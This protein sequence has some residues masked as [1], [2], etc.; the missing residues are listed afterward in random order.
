MQKSLT[1]FLD[2][3]FAKY[4]Y[5]VLVLIFV[6]VAI[7]MWVVF[8]ILGWALVLGEVLFV[9]SL[10]CLLAGLNRPS[11]FDKL[12]KGN[13]NKK[14]IGIVFGIA[15]LI[16]FIFIS[17][18]SFKSG[19]QEYSPQNVLQEVMI[20]V[21]LLAICFYFLPTFIAYKRNK[22]NKIAIFALDLCLGWT[23]VGWVIA[24]V[25]SLTFEGK[26]K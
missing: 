24:L 1:E 7:M 18:V 10:F 6:L 3:A 11:W 21:I 4:F 12:F 19:K 25:W 23:L 13:A 26:N 15:T 5:W 14:R 16:L 20:I 2:R 9:F 22:K 17:N 8:H